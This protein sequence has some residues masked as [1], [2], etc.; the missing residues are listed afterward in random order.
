[1][2]PEYALKFDGAS[3]VDLQRFPIDHNGPITIEAF[4]TQGED[5]APKI[6]DNFVLGVKA[7]FMLKALRS[8][9]WAFAFGVPQGAKAQQY[10]MA[11]EPA[12]RGTRQHLAAV[13]DGKHYRLFVDG[14]L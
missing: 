10:I 3:V 8:G 14:R 5:F 7:R 13:R 6:A 2:S 9:Q 4:A 1:P 11:E 12:P